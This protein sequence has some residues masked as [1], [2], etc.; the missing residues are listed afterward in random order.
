MQASGSSSL[1]ELHD[2]LAIHGDRFLLFLYH[3]QCTAGFENLIGT[4]T[5]G[6]LVFFR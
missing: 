5:S 1:K 2:D 3:R 4:P 6:L